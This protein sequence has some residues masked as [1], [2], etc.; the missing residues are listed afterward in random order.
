MVESNQWSTDGHDELTHVLVRFS[1]IG[2]KSRSVQRRML[3]QLRSRVEERLEYEGIAATVQHAQGRIVIQ[4]QDAQKAAAS[5]GE[6]PGVRSASPA[7]RVPPTIESMQQAAG[8]FPVG[9]TFGVRANIAGDH[10]V[11]SRDVEAAVGEFIETE[12]GAAVDLD[13]PDTW[14]EVDVRSD[15]AFVF[16]ERFEGPGG[17]PV[18]AQASVAALISGGIDSP[19]AAYEM[20]T[21]G[22]DIVP[23][24]FYNK[25]MAAG[26]HVVRFEAA[27]SK[28]IRFN[29]ARNWSYFRVDM[30]E[31]NTALLEIG[32]GR[33]ILHRVIMFRVAEEI[34]AREELSGI[35]TGESIG[36]KSSQTIANLNVTS[37]AVDI[38]VFRPLLTR[39]KEEIVEEAKRLGTFEEA[40]VNSAC[41]SLAPASPATSLTETAFTDLASAVDLDGL[42]ADTCTQIEHVE[43]AAV[44]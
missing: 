39:P 13:A 26:D 1:E 22:V 10:G 9:E 18:G 44:A 42:V 5:V 19:V 43:L 32:R 33:M 29:P 12:T 28:L 6:L 23:V 37:T 15:A 36:Q 3:D 31:T 21:R 25:P 20:M 27:L 34:A 8:V 41:R 17:F 11:T 38:P 35:V 24:Y 40:T 2:T 14:I 30:E 4:C 7:I 16:T